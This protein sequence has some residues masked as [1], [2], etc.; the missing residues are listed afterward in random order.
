MTVQRT[1]DKRMKR[2]NILPA[3]LMVC[4]LSF[5][6]R[7]LYADG[8]LIADS[9]I[10]EPLTVQYHRVSISIEN[11]LALTRVDQVFKNHLDMDLEATYIFPLPEDAAIS[12]F[13]L[14][15][16]GRKVS[17]EI[18]N[19]DEA[20]RV[21][22]EIV[23]KMKDPGLLEYIGRNMFRARIYP[24]PG[25]GK[26]RMELVYGQTLPYEAGVFEYVYPL[27]TERFS[28]KPL[29]EVTISAELHSDIP[30][31]SIYSPSHD[32][33][34]SS[35]TYDAEISFEARDVKPDRD[36]VFYYTVSEDDVGLNLISFRESPDA[37]YFLLMLAPGSAAGDAGLERSVMNKDVLFVLDTSGSMNGEKLQQAKE[38]LRFCVNSLDSGD[39]FNVVQFAT[40]ENRFR[41]GL[42]SASSRNVE[43]ALRFIK[44]FRARGGTNINDALVSSLGM[45]DGSERP[46]MVV[47][48]T[49]G[50]PT[51]GVTELGDIVRN[52]RR[53]N[54]KEARIFVFGV[55]HDVNTHLLDRISEMNRG[56][57]AYVAPL[58][59]IEVKV[60]LFFRKVSEPILSD[61]ELD[62]GKVRVRDIYPVVLPDIFRGTQLVLL[63]R[64]ES[65]GPTAIT[66]T[67]KVNGKLERFVFEGNF[68]GNDT[69][70]DFIP[71]LWA[72]RKIGY[73]TGEIRLNG[74]KEELVEE[75]V[76][77][78]KEYGVMT[79][80]TS[81][82]VL[83]TDADYEE[84]GI[85]PSPELKDSG[86]RYKKS[87][88]AET[89]AGAVSSARDIIAL[90]ESQTEQQPVLETI[91]W[92]GHKTFYL[93]DGMWVDSDY[94]EGMKQREIDYLSRAYF[95]VLK[96]NPELGRYFALAK[97][98]IVVHNSKAYRVVDK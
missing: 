81:F 30:I 9:P 64:Y 58:E 53:E 94:R 32:V 48:L 34:I 23:R 65:N 66:L 15:V 89:G 33:D 19:K 91:K 17:G 84:W 29:E 13:A 73:L 60:S 18:L 16:D 92:V 39:R 75:I 44:R 55:G 82:L 36:F 47:F 10:M 1:E 26:T 22:E 7:T 45:F 37:G 72:T 69:E 35:K 71:R 2:L 50:E 6:A 87:M 90:K 28:P 88:E 56:V 25:R 78:S 31:K 52:I 68:P 14:W 93:R 46:N 61:I 57:S 96:K 12:D 98:V 20:R 62:F 97:D 40:S 54:P 49:D 59:N 85:E 27:D 38:A 76:R 51:V 43:D 79:P 4:T 77:L 21:Y 86:I 74:E 70:H 67:G 24:V 80:Y 95:D 5:L 63:G 3:V 8:V 83:E 11:G 41:E 42:V